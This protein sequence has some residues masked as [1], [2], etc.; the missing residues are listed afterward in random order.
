LG[1]LG[2]AKK[3]QEYAEHLGDTYTQA[4]SAHRQARC[5]LL[6]ANYKLAETLLHNAKDLLNSCGL[7]GKTLDMNI[8][9]LEAE[10]HL[11]KTE[12]L[13]S[14]KIQVS[15][16]TSL[17]PTTYQ[18]IGTNLNISLID[19]AIGADSEH[20]Q[21]SLNTSEL[22]IKGLHGHMQAYM[23][24]W[25]DVRSAD[26]SLRDGAHSEA[27]A[28]FVRCFSSCHNIMLEEGLL[29]LERLA[30]LSMGMTNVQTTLHWA[31]MYLGLASKSMD[32]IMTMQ[33]FRCLGQI[34]AAMG[35]A[36]TALSLLNVALDGFTFMDVHRWRADCM[37]K[38]ADILEQRGELK[39]AVEMWEAARPLFER[40]SQ[41]K[42]ITRINMKLAR[43]DPKVL[44]EENLLR[45]GYLDKFDVY[46][47]RNQDIS[48]V[49]Q[50][51]A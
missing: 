9:N 15:I 30:D 12:Y 6:F 40:S 10:I 35:D 51:A 2:H 42:D 41:G 16:L 4:I 1:A 27:Y 36:E 38:I 34:S 43:L 23:N 37:V 47:L 3:A 11:L 22:Y 31:V 21:Q 8:K 50:I 7:Q 13:E 5:Q 45:P 28:K 49:Q 29:C 46:D 32:K 18:A 39:R 24:V 48:G 26:L 20:V 19:I 33:A 14:R 44:Q 25:L 17:Q